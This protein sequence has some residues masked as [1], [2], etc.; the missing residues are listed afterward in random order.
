M[1][2]PRLSKLETAKKSLM[3]LLLRMASNKHVIYRHSFSALLYNTL[4][5]GQQI[6]HSHHAEIPIQNSQSHSKCT[7]VYNN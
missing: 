2:L 7:P 1:G 3:S 5:L 4:G 6:Q